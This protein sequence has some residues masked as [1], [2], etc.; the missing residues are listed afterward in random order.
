[1]RVRV[2]VR[3]VSDDVAVVDTAIG[4]M[5]AQLRGDVDAPLGRPVDVEF[6]IDV[7]ATDGDVVD[8]ASAGGQAPSARVCGSLSVLVGCV[9]GVDGDGV[10]Y[11][12]LAPDCLVLLETDGSLTPGSWV[13]L[14]IAPPS[15]G[16]FV[17]GC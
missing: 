9:E 2:L 4:S 8:F 15:I 16:V 6:T 3:E 7:I 11:L 10:G 13:E 14:R 12:R 5:R 1:V 17:T